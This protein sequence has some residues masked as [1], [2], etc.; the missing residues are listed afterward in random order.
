MQLVI[1]K[2]TTLL[3][4]KLR[5]GPESDRDLIMRPR[6][7]LISVIQVL[8]TATRR[9]ICTKYFELSFLATALSPHFLSITIKSRVVAVNQG[10]TRALLRHPPSITEQASFGML[11]NPEPV[12]LTAPLMRCGWVCLRH[13][14]APP[15]SFPPNTFVF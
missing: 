10:T 5:E 15:S 9:G 1:P 7:T 3:S 4:K 14:Y 2:E 6:R 11:A 8:F 13:D 12:S